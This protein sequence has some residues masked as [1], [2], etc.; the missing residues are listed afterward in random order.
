MNGE[1]L[2]REPRA[3]V[4]VVRPGGSA[5][6][7]GGVPQAPPMPVAPPTSLPPWFDRATS[8]SGPGNGTGHGSGHGTGD[9]TGPG[10]EHGSG[11][12]SG[13][14]GH[15]SGHGNEPEVGP[16]ADLT[17][18]QREVRDLLHRAVGELAPMPGALEQIRRAVPRRRQRRRRVLGSVVA[19]VFLCSLGTIAL[20]SA[21]MSINSADGPQSSQ[22]YGDAASNGPSHG[23]HVSAGASLAPAGPGRVLPGVGSS[24]AGGDSTN[25]HNSATVLPGASGVL[26]P[27]PSLSRPAAGSSVSAGAS[28]GSAHGSTGP[29]AEC[30]RGQLGNG[31]DTVG[32][33]DAAGVVYGTFQV[34]NVSGSTCRVSTPGAVAVLAVSGT[35]KS[36]ISVAQH[37]AGDPAGGL[38][39][40]AAKP[41]PV[42]LAP[43]D[44]YLVEFAWVPASGTGTPSCTASSASGSSASA[45]PGSD[46]TTQ[47]SVSAGADTGAPSGAG[48]TPTVTLGHTPGAGG[49]AAAS[50]VIGNA[51]AGTVYRTSPLPAR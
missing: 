2:P 1:E 31:A 23:A 43:G 5:G 34:S 8:G 51:C 40:P 9:G 25:G 4:R 44:S 38:P 3:A 20:H 15:D 7:A 11:Q 48:S 13:H 45:A 46:D 39:A 36:W 27:N 41:A 21:G 6:R 10:A 17:P 14:S 28:G 29:V 49:T 30:V 33:P 50:A 16:G 47:G 26:Q 37:T 22:Q 19:T 12:D 18:E 24:F 42:V 35:D 32:S